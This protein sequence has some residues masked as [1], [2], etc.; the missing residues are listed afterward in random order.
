MDTV[1]LQN[2]EVPL[3]Q[4][5]PLIQERLASGQ[6]VKF[7]PKGTS[8]LPMLRQGIDSVVLSPLPEKLNKYDLPLYRRADGSF[9]LHRIVVVG[10]TY[11]CIG[12]NQYIE[13]TGV[14]HRQM[15]AL[16]TAFYRG[17]KRLSVSRPSYRLYCRLWH[18]SRFPRRLLLWLKR[19]IRRLL[20]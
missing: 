3:A 7:S 4:L 17:Q 12:D 8:M 18:Y 5:L 15:L 13:E 1:S 14:S 19:K 9:V 2:K 6:T 10:D 16:V 20:R 11:T